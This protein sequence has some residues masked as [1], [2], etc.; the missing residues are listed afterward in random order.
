MENDTNEPEQNTEVLL[1]RSD[2][3]SGRYLLGRY[4]V[5]ERLAVGG[6]AEIY[7]AT[8]GQLAGFQTPLVIKRILPNLAHTREFTEMFLDEARIAALLQHPNIATILEVGRE[9]DE[10]F[11]AMELVQGEQL[12]QVIRTLTAKK[13]KL[14]PTLAAF[15]ASQVAAGLHY[16]H[17]VCDPS[18]EP[19][20][21]VH[22]DIS[23]QNILISYEGAVKIIDF[24]IARAMGR[25]T[26]TRVGSAKGKFSYMSPEQ[27]RREGVDHRSDIFSLG[28]VLWEMITGERLFRR[29]ND[30]DTVDAILSDTPPPLD[31]F[32]TVSPHLQTIVDRALAKDVDQRFSSAI[33]METLLQTYL[34]EE[35]FSGQ[36]ELRR[37][38]HQNF[39]GQQIAW[40]HRVRR[41]LSRFTPTPEATPLPPAAEPNEVPIEPIN[42]FPYEQREPPTS[43]LAFGVWILVGLAMVISFASIFL[44][45]E[46]MQRP[47]H[48]SEP[49]KTQIRPPQV[50]PFPTHP[51]T[52][53]PVPA[54]KTEVTTR[55]PPATRE[56]S[57]VRKRPKTN[58]KGSSSAQALKPNPFAF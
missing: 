18:G 2:D 56:R 26:H 23:P 37:F 50:N 55:E 32:S 20:H 31:K 9:R 35:A 10:Y 13:E 8:H 46:I 5:T 43:K 14:T 34:S 49:I 52:P 7:L 12:S 39:S 41:A 42:E 28:V 3:L 17:S 1:N 44:V 30:L 11:L 15:I 53:N 27:G 25:V 57:D 58:S 19:L 21:V 16:A 45:K 36:P 6:M 51:V 40:R 38:M 24:G 54:I 47:V 29:Q 4:L 22:R 48:P 33:E